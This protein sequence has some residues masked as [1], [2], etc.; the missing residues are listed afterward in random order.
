MNGESKSLK[1]EEVEAS[2]MEV[3]PFI[4]SKYGLNDIF[5]AYE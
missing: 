4:L 5:N 3:L 2:E 1:E